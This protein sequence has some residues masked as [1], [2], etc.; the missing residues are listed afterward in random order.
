MKTKCL[1]AMYGLALVLTGCHSNGPGTVARDRYDDSSSLGEPWKR[2]TLHNNVKLRYLDPPMF[3]G[4]GQNAS[5]YTLGTGLGVSG[6]F[7]SDKAVH[8]DFM[9]GNGQAVYTDRPIISYTP[10]SGNK[11]VKGL[12]TPLT[13]ISVYFTIQS[14]WPA[15]GVLFAT[16]SE[17]NDLKNRG[18]ANHGVAPPD[19]RFMRLLRLMREIRL[20]GAVAMRIEQNKNNHQ[21]TI[22]TFRSNDIEPETLDEVHELRGLL[23]LNPDAEEIQL[24]FGSGASN[25]RKAARITRSMMQLMG[26]MATQVDV[27]AKK[28]AQRRATPGW[29]TITNTAGTP[30]MIQIHS[31]KE[32]LK[33]LFATIPYRDHWFCINDLDLYQSALAPS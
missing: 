26:T 33:D 1:L 6:T 32:A 11:F 8:G 31:S 9:N 25:D 22:F 3:A 27:P 10:L 24:V 13:P 17:I 19:P 4:V 2:Q 30:R 12:M 5:G 20:C 18:K 28:L 29:E 14:C 7:S 21:N 15:D 16:V 23:R